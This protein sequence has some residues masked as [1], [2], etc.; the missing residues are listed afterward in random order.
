MPPEST[1]GAPPGSTRSSRWLPPLL[2]AGII[3]IGTSW[4]SISV[5]PDDIIGVDKAMHFGMYGL[6]TVLVVRAL[7][8]PISLRWAL[9]VLVALS[10]FGAADEW[11]QGFITGRSSSIYDWIADTLGTISGLWVSRYLLTPTSAGLRRRSSEPT[12]RTT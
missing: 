9:I 3:L 11:H 8:P 2:W 7:Q 12:T 10:G 5:G 6:L 4:P 1:P